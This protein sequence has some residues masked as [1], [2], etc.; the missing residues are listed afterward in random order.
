VSACPSCG[1]STTDASDFCSGCGAYLRWD[2]EEAAEQVTEVHAVEPEP[3]A[4][5]TATAVLEPTATIPADQVSLTLTLPGG[6]GA[7]GPPTIGVEAGGRANLSATLFNQSGIVDTYD[8]RLRG[9]PDGWYTITPA[10][11]NLLPFGAEQDH[12]EEHIA[13]VLHPPQAPEAEARQWPIALVARSRSRGED[14][15]EAA[16]MVVIAPFERF[17]CRVRPQLVRGQVSAEYLVPVRNLGNAPLH[18]AL[19]GEDDE[20]M[21]RVAFDPPR[22][23]IPAGGE[24]RAALTVSAA[25]LRDVPEQRRAVSVLVEGASQRT[26]SHATFLQT[27]T[28]TRKTPW[29]LILGLLGAALVLISAFA[30]WGHGDQALCL[31]GRADNCLSY[32]TYVNDAFSNDISQAHVSG[33]EGVFDFGTSLGVLALVLGLA[34]LVGLRGR[35]MTL[36]AGIL[37]AVLAIVLLVTLKS[38]ASAG[39]AVLLIGGLLAAVAGA[40]APRK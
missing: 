23:T 16:G 32:S 19:S 12:A 6:N 25:R 31:H 27:P 15:V 40:L 4:A 34:A 2:E 33:L 22:L 11:V 1:A 3:A 30:H 35:S 28:I 7:D 14:A 36:V 9:L 26:E 17:D 18:V 24:A 20:G 29:W 37:S 13:I 5:P 10:T 8:L 38:H 39:I 21:T